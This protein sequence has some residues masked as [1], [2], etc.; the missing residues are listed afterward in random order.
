MSSHICAKCG[1]LLTLS[2]SNEP[3]PHCG[4]RERIVVALDVAVAAEKEAAAAEL[5]KIHYNLEAGLSQIFRLTS[6]ARSE[7]SPT[8]P[9]KL[10][11][12]NEDTV[13]SGVMPLNFGPMPNRGINFPS[14]IIEV[15]PNEFKRIQMH[16]LRLPE[17]WQIREELPRPFENLGG[18]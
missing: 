8:E 4:S 10:L 6:S 5:A 1:K 15:T 7:V 2:Q 12:V 16:E 3:C 11:E 13:E 14:T 18:A 9:I 17:G